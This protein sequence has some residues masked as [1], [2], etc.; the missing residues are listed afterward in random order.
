MPSVLCILQLYE[1]TFSNILAYCV[2]VYAQQNILKRYQSACYMYAC[3]LMLK[4]AQGAI[5]Q[6]SKRLLHAHLGPPLSEPAE[7]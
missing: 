5:L 3:I 2:H 4:K 7:S 1:H 6:H